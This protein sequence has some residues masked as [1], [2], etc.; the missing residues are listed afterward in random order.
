MPVARIAYDES[1]STANA[2]QRGDQTVKVLASLILATTLGL[3]PSIQLCSAGTVDMNGVWASQTG[4]VYSITQRNLDVSAI[5]S[6]PNPDQS[7]T[8]VRNGDVAFLGRL[9]D[10][11]LHVTFYQRISYLPACPPRWFLSLIDFRMVSGGNAL[12][13]DLPLIHIND[14]CAVDESGLQHLILRRSVPAVAQSYAV[15]SKLLPV[16]TPTKPHKRTFAPTESSDRAAKYH[17]PAGQIY[18]VSMNICVSM[19]AWKAFLN[20][21]TGEGVK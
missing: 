11:H 21:S 6:T 16:G 20:S 18:R 7:A 19:E 10:N 17:C 9:S 14:H 12:E 3:G 8:G 5:Y 1:H 15:P 4:A 13:G 2:P